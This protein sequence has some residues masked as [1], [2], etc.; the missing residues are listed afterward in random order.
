MTKPFKYNEDKICD[1]I[2][3]YI[4]ETYGKHYS[5]GADGFQVQDLLKTLK[6]SKIN[7]NPVFLRKSLTLNGADSTSIYYHLQCLL[8]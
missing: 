1:E 8:K 3:G 5:I 2:K 4:K 6:I 7:S